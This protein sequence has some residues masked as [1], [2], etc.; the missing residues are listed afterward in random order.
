MHTFNKF[1]NTLKIEREHKELKENYTLL[2]P[3]DERKYMMVKEIL[4]KYV[5]L[6]K[7]C[8][9]EKEKKK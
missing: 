2:D 5:D 8:Q 4:Y 9:K 3:S 6:E 7:T 1:I